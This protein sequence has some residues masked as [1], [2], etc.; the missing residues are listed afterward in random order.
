MDLCNDRFESSRQCGCGFCLSWPDDWRAFLRTRANILVT[1]PN[2]ALKAFV[3]AARPEFREPIRLV[4]GGRT[5]GL[6]TA[7]TLFLRNVDRLSRAA[8]RMLLAWM[9][10]PEH[11][12][13]QI[14]ST[15]SVPLFPLVQA[16][17]FDP[18][19]YYRLNTIWLEVQVRQ[20]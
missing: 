17:G 1:G 4:V 7:G 15:A 18:N 3:H 20:P 5:V 11:A 19:L 16:E 9:N 13:T 10:E 2:A 14:V 8:Q 12:G 6:Q